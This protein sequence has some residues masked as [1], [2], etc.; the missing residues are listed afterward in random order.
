M[1][2]RNQ[3]RDILGDEHIEF[4][5]NLLASLLDNL[6]REY[7]KEFA[8]RRS[9]FLRA[10]LQDDLEKEARFIGGAVESKKWSYLYETKVSL[11]QH[12]AL[13]SNV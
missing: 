10:Y 9:F 3:A 1:I 12:S 13:P 2:D 11:R 4:A 8:L 7:E 5:S 6:L